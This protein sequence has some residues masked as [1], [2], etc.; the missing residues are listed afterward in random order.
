L[1]KRGVVVVKSNERPEPAI[2]IF[3]IET[4][5]DIP[6]FLS[7]YKKD[8]VLEY[9]PHWNDLSLYDSL[10]KELSIDFPQTIYHAVVSICGV[11]IEPETYKIMDGFK[12]TLHLPKDYKD[13]KEQEKKLLED[14]WK[15]T[16]KYE[17][18]HNVW[19]DANLSDRFISDYQRKKLKK[20]PLIFCGY[21]I[22]S[23]DLPVI[24]QRSLIH[25]IQ[26]PIDDYAKILGTDSYRYK[27]A[28]DKVFDLL[29]FVCNY[30]NKN[31]RIG[32][33]ILTKALGISGKLDGMAGSEV[34]SV[35]YE[36]KDSA[37][38]EEYCSID[39]LITY[40]VF[41]SIQNYRGI[42]E[43]ENYKLVKDWFYQWLLKEGKPQ[44]YKDLALKSPSYFKTSNLI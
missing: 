31:A 41:L 32:L 25:E 13:F 26:C 43:K 1:S 36:K 20:L 27:Y 37:L 28:Q 8:E 16:L 35:F 23:F 22:T 19:Y 30:D 4:V 42:L 40:A 38:I 7:N 11:F 24:E 18:L 6:L 9:A 44:S 15:F 12:R 29:N 5:P 14:F 21:N 2:L 39:V 34:A 3:D 17:N 33:N 10:R